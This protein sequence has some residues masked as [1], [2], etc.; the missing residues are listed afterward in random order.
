[1]NCIVKIEPNYI[2]IY[3]FINGVS[4]VALFKR[5]NIDD[6]MRKV[7]IE[8]LVGYNHLPPRYGEY[9]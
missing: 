5:V 8:S 1:M 2:Y 6:R 3:V 7:D 9:S 4:C